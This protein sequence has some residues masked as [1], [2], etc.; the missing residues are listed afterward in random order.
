MQ[1]KQ[2]KN[3]EERQ[4]VRAK[5]IAKRVHPD[6]PSETTMDSTNPFSR[7]TSPCILSLSWVDEPIKEFDSLHTFHT[8]SSVATHVATPQ[9]CDDTS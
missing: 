7:L 1:K 2:K 9:I 4:K 8:E 6:S 3:L 5:V